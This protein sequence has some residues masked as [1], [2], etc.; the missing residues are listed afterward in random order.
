M[1][2]VIQLE[3]SLKSSLQLGHA[4]YRMS[5][6]GHLLRNSFLLEVTPHRNDRL[7]L[8]CATASGQFGRQ[9]RRRTV[10]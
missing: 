4:R 3:S 5:H 6:L 10:S 9:T 1:G 8:R 7:S 2:Q